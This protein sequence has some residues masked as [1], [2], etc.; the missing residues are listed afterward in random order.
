MF[1]A[2]RELKH[3]KFRYLLIG[4]IMLLVAWLT[5]IVSG[6]ANGLALDNASALKNMNG[7][8]F[9]LQD[10]A[11]QKLARSSI[12]TDTLD[13]ISKQDGVKEATPLAQTTTSFTQT[14]KDKK[15]DVTIFGIDPKSMIMPNISE[16]RGIANLG[17]NEV[18]VDESLK[19]KNGIA[20]GDTLE[21]KDTGVSVTVVGFAKGQTFSH[22]PVLYTDTDSLNNIMK[23]T[24]RQ[25]KPSYNA[26]V[27]KGTKDA[28]TSLEKNV[29]HISVLTKDQA[30]QGIPGYKEEQG[31]LTMMI[32]FL[33]VIAAFV[34]AVFFYVIT[35]QKTNQ[36]GVLKAIGAKTSYL[37]KN[38]ISQVLILAITAVGISIAL[39]FGVSALFPAGMPFD[40]G[41]DVMLKYSALLI[42]VA[43][44]GALLSLQQIAKIDAVTAIGRA[45]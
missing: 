38:L 34:Q 9:V 15:V 22:M 28:Q 24:G 41:I 40:L 33:I 17:K 11:D 12:P 2:L 32:T 23:S 44:I 45:E 7:D 39:T 43:V 10:N 27:V 30:V 36:F 13:E 31:S 29:S 21:N 18:V 6:L 42:V 26:I 14:G 16:G 8:Y 35:L 3:A 20:I 4:F 19:E 5:F 25:Q 37:A 1:L